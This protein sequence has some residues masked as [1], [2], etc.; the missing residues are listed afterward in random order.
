MH[1]KQVHDNVVLGAWVHRVRKQGREGR[2]PPLQ[3]AKLEELLFVWK[4]DLQ[5]ANWHYLLHEARRYKVRRAGLW[6]PH[7]GYECIV[8]GADLPLPKSCC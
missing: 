2:L 3:M 1:G 8:C 7:N 6:L 5:S 4:V